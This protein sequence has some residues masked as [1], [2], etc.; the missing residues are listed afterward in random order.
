[1]ALVGLYRSHSDF[2]VSTSEGTILWSSGTAGQ[3]EGCQLRIQKNRDIVIYSSDGSLIWHSNTQLPPP[4]RLEDR[5]DSLDT[6]GGSGWSQLNSANGRYSVILQNDGNLAAFQDSETSPFWSTSTNGQG[7]APY[8]LLVENCNL[9]LK[10]ATN[11]R[12]WSTNTHAHYSDCYFGIDND[13]NIYV[14]GDDRILWSSGTV[15]KPPTL[16]PVRHTVS[17]KF[18]PISIGPYVTS[19]EYASKTS[20]SEEVDSE[21]QFIVASNGTMMAYIVPLNGY[22]TDQ[23]SFLYW[24]NDIIPKQWRN[25]QPIES[26][27]PFGL[28][29]KDDCNMQIVDAYGA[30]YFESDTGGMHDVDCVFT[31]NDDGEA[32]LIDNETGT[33]LFSF[34]NPMNSVCD[35]ATELLLDSNFELLRAQS[36]FASRFVAEDIPFNCLNAGNGG[37][38]FTVEKSQPGTLHIATCSSTPL[39]DIEHSIAVY[40]GDCDS[41]LT[42]VAISQPCAQP[43]R[44]AEL[45]L[46][47]AANQPYYFYISSNQADNMWFAFD[48]NANFTSSC[49]NSNCDI[50]ETYANCRRDCSVACGDN[51]C[52]NGNYHSGQDCPYDCPSCGDGVCGTD[53]DCEQDCPPTT[54]CGNGICDENE[55]Y[56]VCRRDCSPCSSATNIERSL[57]AVIE[58]NYDAPTMLSSSTCGIC[59]NSPFPDYFNEPQEYQYTVLE[60]GIN[61][62]WFR[63]P[64]QSN[65]YSLKLSSDSF[66]GY[67]TGSF[68]C[69]KE[70]KQAICFTISTILTLLI[71]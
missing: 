23:G 13:R 6:F 16:R 38:W 31:W 60:S 11:E 12:L 47:I 54:L 51:I 27:E 25:T 61:L 21:Y 32:I 66:T 18:N 30:A 36:T 65:S 48:L 62:F 2:V 68:G 71:L 70:N 40:S 49:G 64:P 24:K 45:T 43:D 55:D 69:M 41:A 57:S 8:T 1:M 33:T 52:G 39:S 9:V 46:S 44:G 42:C 29:L 34:M 28:V 19:K 59:L 5:V 4:N 14:F 67:D 37:T 63:I 35:G 7:V 26:V 17:K 53:E 20:P 50:H 22:Y 15:I 3:G 10:D 56:V 58:I